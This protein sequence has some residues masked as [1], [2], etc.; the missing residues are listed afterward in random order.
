MGFAIPKFGSTIGGIPEGAVKRRSVLDGVR[1]DGNVFED[2]FIQRRPDGR[3]HAIHHAAGSDDVGSS[4]S[5]GNSDLP[6]NLQRG[7]VVNIALGQLLVRS[8]PAFKT[9]Q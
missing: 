5:V 2:S 1:K 8:A 7:V 3:D 4:L 6:Q 9:P